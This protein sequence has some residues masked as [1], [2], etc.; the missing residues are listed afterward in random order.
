LFFSIDE[1]DDI[2]L[3]SPLVFVNRSLNL[4]VDSPTISDQ[5][6][7]SKSRL[8]E[9][10]KKEFHPNG[11]NHHQ[12]YPHCPTNYTR[13]PHSLRNKNP[14]PTGSLPLSLTNNP[15]LRRPSPQ[16]ETVRTPIQK[17]P[18]TIP[19][20]LFDCC[21]TSVSQRRSHRQSTTTTTMENN[22]NE[23]ENRS[24][25]FREVKTIREIMLNVS[26]RLTQD[27]DSSTSLPIVDTHCHFD[28]I[29][30]R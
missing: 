12:F 5:T 16:F 29:F 6:A 20:E 18:S 19:F 8:S 23:S 26:K 9:R 22:L 21:Q 17:S 15:P 7:T 24:N 11:N 25:Y 14:S 28:L 3:N 4:P 30:D 13:L 10:S 27:L 2:N 1:D